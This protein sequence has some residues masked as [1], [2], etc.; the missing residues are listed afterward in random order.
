MKEEKVIVRC[1]CERCGH[2]WDARSGDSGGSPVT[3]PHCRSPYWNMKRKE[4]EAINHEEFLG[5]N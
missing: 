3:C 5:K 1:T 2:A 4:R